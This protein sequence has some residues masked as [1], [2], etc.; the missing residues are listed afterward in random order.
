MRFLVSISLSLS[1][2]LT[3]LLSR[4]FLAI[5]SKDFTRTFQA[6]KN[7][8][9][10]NNRI[11]RVSR[12]IQV[13]LV[14]WFSSFALLLYM[15]MFMF[16]F[17]LSLYL[18]FEIFFFFRFFLF[19]FISASVSPSFFLSFFLPS[20]HMCV[21]VLFLYRCEH[22]PSLCVVTGLVCVLF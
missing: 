22:A 14:C 19:L 15:F 16:N 10:S 5:L 21:S 2:S 13:A 8:K 18:S 3:L 6:V 1:V 9:N 4:L 11:R 20:R 7:Q 17:V 12:K